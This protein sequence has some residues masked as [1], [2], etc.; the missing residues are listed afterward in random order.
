MVTQ[1][2]TFGGVVVKKKSMIICIFIA[3]LFVASLLFWFGLRRNENI[4]P[5]YRGIAFDTFYNIIA[6]NNYHM[7]GR[8]IHEDGTQ[9][10]FEVYRKN[11]MVVYVYENGRTIARDGKIYDF[12]DMLP[13]F[14]LLSVQPDSF[15][16]DRANDADGIAFAGRGSAEFN[17]R[18]LPYEKY[19][20]AHGDIRYFFFDG[21]ALVGM[22]IFSARFDDVK[23]TIIYVLNHD[24]PAEVFEIPI[25]YQEFNAEEHGHLIDWG[26]MW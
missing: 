5:D 20:F 16:G 2:K 7:I 13:G 18:M 19:I 14:Y 3:I 17:G 23:D 15:L 25:G 22:R 24:V 6:T 4:N 1:L 26:E 11:D 8:D 9:E 10:N 21:D 12:H